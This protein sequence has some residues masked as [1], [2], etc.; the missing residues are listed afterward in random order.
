MQ[1]PGLGAYRR[2][3]Q[4]A[5][6]SGA[7]RSAL[8]SSRSLL[9]VRCPLLVG[10]KADAVGYDPEGVGEVEQGEGAVV[11]VKVEAEVEVDDAAQ[12]AM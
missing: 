2:C 3:R 1:G 8:R 7:R 4:C 6:V 10:W 12:I 9:K 5:S 11:A